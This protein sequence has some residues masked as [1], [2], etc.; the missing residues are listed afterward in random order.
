MVGKNQ[1][2]LDVCSLKSRVLTCANWCGYC[3][4]TSVDKVNRVCIQSE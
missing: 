1:H 2:C 4:L 3:V